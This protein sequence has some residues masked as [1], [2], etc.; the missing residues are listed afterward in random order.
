MF[1]S[2]LEGNFFF[3][4]RLILRGAECVVLPALR[5]DGVQIFPDEGIEGGLLFRL[6]AARQLVNT[7]ATDLPW[8]FPKWIDRAVAFTLS[9]GIAFG[10]ES[11][12]RS[13]YFNQLV[14]SEG[15]QYESETIDD[16]TTRWLVSTPWELVYGDASSPAYGDTLR[17]ERTDD[18]DTLPAWI[19]LEL[20]RI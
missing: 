14:I 8:L 3:P 15:G 6:E 13:P 20:I 5:A 2:K 17:F 16:V 12:R 7:P 9:G 1:Q 18:N 19:E 11:D 10:V 4:W